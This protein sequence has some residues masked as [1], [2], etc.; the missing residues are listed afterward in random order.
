VTYGYNKTDVQSS[1]TDFNGNQI[2]ISNDGDGLP[3]S[4]TLGSTGDTIS[5]S[6]DGTDTP[7]VIALKNS[8]STLESF[9]YSAAPDGDIVSEA[10]VPSSSKSPAT[11]AYDSQN[12]VTSMTPGTAS[13]LN[14]T[15][16]A[17]GNLTTLPT[18]ATASYDD[19]SELTSSTLSGTT[20]SYTYNADGQQLVREQGSS[21]V[22]SAAWNGADELTSYNNSS[23]D[24]SAAT[25]DGDGLRA[26]ETLTAGGSSSA[27]NFVWG[28]A[29]DNLLMD[30]S[31]AYIYGTG[32]SPDEQVSLT[33]GKISYLTVDML[34]SVRG[35]VSTAGALTA[36]TA[37]DAWGNPQTSGG[38]T[39]LTPFGYAGA[40][41]DPTG[42]LYLINRYYDPPTGQFISTD[43]AVGV[44][45]EPYEYANGNPVSISD[46]NGTLVVKVE[47]LH[48]R[49]YFN[50]YE[51]GI[52]ASRFTG[53]T[54]FVA[55][56]VYTWLKAAGHV[57]GFLD[58][59]LAD[60]IFNALPL[61]HKV[62]VRARN[63]KRGYCVQLNVE[64]LVGSYTANVYKL[65]HGPVQDSGE[66]KGRFLYYCSGKWIKKRKLHD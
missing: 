63:G 49:F 20:T 21:T 56:L 53:L 1:I 45:G 8:S 14:Y 3:S 51:T 27:Q 42:L 25:Y 4:E 31:N 62:A 52:I 28:Q 33:T 44:T 16:D 66:H 59:G 54:S 36:T 23:A 35:V 43:P 22:A 39:S 57:P 2:T 17:S 29:N 38:L 37:Y 5:T 65:T 55:A 64:Y 46:P 58:D 7:S 30:S 13:Q 40:Y 11:Y 15:F 6:Y 9:S 47:G 41:T 19:D 60:I 48:L 18:G 12:R 10:D 34:G 32:Q 61:I 26:T 50:H 24:M